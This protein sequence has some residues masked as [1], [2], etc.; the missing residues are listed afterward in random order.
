MPL[1]QTFTLNRSADKQ[2][3]LVT[4]TTGAYDATTNPTGYGGVNPSAS[5]FTALSISMYLPD[6]VTLQPSTTAIPITAIFP[7]LPSETNGTYTI[8]ST[9][10]LG[11]ETVLVDGLYKGI[12]TATYDIGAGDVS[13]SPITIYKP[14]YYIAECCWQQNMLEV[15]TCGDKEK[16]E[17]LTFGGAILQMLSP[18]INSLGVVVLSP[19]E[20]CENWNK[21]VEF[22]LY[23]KELCE[24]FNCGGGCQS[25]H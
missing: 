18:Y 1:E 7:T 4:D 24:E 10:L 11:S 23:L 8:T 25:C 19:I 9:A 12:I 3:L 21:S 15:S 17:R 2:N 22:M 5:D 16:K 13:I 14:F 6:P 20:Q